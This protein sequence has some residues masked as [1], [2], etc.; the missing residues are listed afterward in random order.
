MTAERRIGD[1]AVR[2][3]TGR[4]WEQWFEILDEWDATDREHKEIAAHLREAHDVAGWWAQTVTVQ[5]ERERGMREVG[6]ASNG[7]NMGT[8]K[9]FLPDVDAAWELIISTDGLSTWLGD[10]AP[11]T[12]KEGE[13]YELDD[14][15]VGEIRVVTPGSH[16]RMTWQPVDWE[17]AS[18]LQVRAMEAGS[19]RGTISFHHEKL[20][21]KETREAMKRHWKTKLAELQQIV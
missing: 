21:D 2:D 19:G 12:L 8:Q 18:T 15:T 4:N 3:A 5:Y 20:P 7:Y 16:V 11:T 9:T 13:H 14:G 10:G 17:R 1:E 6:E